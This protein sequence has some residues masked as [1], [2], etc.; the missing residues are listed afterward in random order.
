MPP[1]EPQITHLHQETWP[2]YWPKPMEISPKKSSVVLRK[3]YWEKYLTLFE[4]YIKQKSYL[5][6]LFHGGFILVSWFR[7]LFFSTERQRRS[8]GRER[9]AK[10]W[11][12]ASR[13]AVNSNIFSKSP[14]LKSQKLKLKRLFWYQKRFC[15]FFRVV[16]VGVRTLPDFAGLC[17]VLG[18]S[19]VRAFNL[20]GN[21]SGY[22]PIHQQ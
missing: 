10:S 18:N 21:F 15:R 19:S 12:A 7:T 9:F 3:K 22:S 17:K 8:D 6:Y 5:K 11:T 14:K 1:T 20:T 16:N 13:K 4:Q 2:H